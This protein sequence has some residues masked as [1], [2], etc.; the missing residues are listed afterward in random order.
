MTASL[1][2]RGYCSTC[3]TCWYSSKKQEGE[4]VRQLLNSCCHFYLCH[5][6][7]QLYYSKKQNKTLPSSSGHTR[8]HTFPFSVSPMCWELVATIN[9]EG[10]AYSGGLLPKSLYPPRLHLSSSRLNSCIVLLRI[11]VS[12]R[13]Y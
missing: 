7:N 2:S 12:H 6:G 9:R 11:S 4:A 13:P 5:S 3:V 10:I 8:T 1:S